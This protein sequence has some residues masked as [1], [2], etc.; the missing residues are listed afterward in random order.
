MC[1]VL[2][3]LSLL[4]FV[5]GKFWNQY[6]GVDADRW[7]VQEGLIYRHEEAILHLLDFPVFASHTA[8]VRYRN[9]DSS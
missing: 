1:A 4:E 7:G 2:V 8:R 5:L 3:V 6:F 9:M